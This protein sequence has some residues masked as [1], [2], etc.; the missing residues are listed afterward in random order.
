MHQSK[1][2]S[3]PEGSSSMITSWKTIQASIACVLPVCTQ[4][5]LTPRAIEKMD[6]AEYKTVTVGVPKFFA[7]KFARQSARNWNKFYKRN[8]VN[9]FRDRHWTT[10]SETDGFPCLSEQH[11]GDNPVPIVVVEA[12]CGVANCAFPL[13]SQNQQLRIFMFDFAESAISLV[14]QSPH[15]DS[16]RCHAF[17]WDF[18]REPFSHVTDPG[19]L[20]IATA[21]FLPS[22]F[23]PQRRA[24]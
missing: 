9:F 13:L 23:C 21:D 14:K 3:L 24:S 22:H 15:F 8:S 16:N 7:D 1:D 4:E 17:L 10:R 6:P 2:F 18:S 20:S 12:G 11:E 19:D 5:R